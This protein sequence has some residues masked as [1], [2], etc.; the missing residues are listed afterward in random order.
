MR[1]I[2]LKSYLI[3]LIIIIASFC[4]LFTTL[5]VLYQSDKQTQQQ[6]NQALNSATKQ[7]HVQLIRVQTNFERPD[8]FPNLSLWQEAENYSGL[9]VRF[10]GLQDRVEQSIC[11]GGGVT[12]SW[13]DWFDGFYRW[14]FRPGKAVEQALSHAGKHYGS[15][16]VLPSVDIAL[17][18]AWQDVRKLMG[19]ATLTIVSLSILLYFAIGYALRPGRVIV[20]EL[21]KMKANEFSSR[22][23]DFFITEW[24][25]MGREMN[26]LAA[27]LQ[28]NLA[29]RK[30]L[31][32]KLV[33][34]Q[35][36]ERKFLARELHDEFGQ[37]LA[38][39]SAVASL[40]TQ[41]AEKD[42][43]P[44]A[45]Q[46]EKVSDITSYMMGL[47]RDMLIRLRPADFDELGLIDS[48]K[49]MI[50][51]WNSQSGG[52]TQYQLEV[53]GD[54]SD[55]N[56]T[57]PVSIFRMA[58]ECLTNIAK[59]SKASNALILLQRI[60][61]TAEPNVSEH[62]LLKIEDDGIASDLTFIRRSGIG[63][64]GLQERVDALGGTLQF[65][66]LT[67]SGLAIHI[68]IPLFNGREVG[69]E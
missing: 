67:P 66:T 12:R 32:L 4:L 18:N 30:A 54:F 55:L 6:T 37:S 19:L 42:Y 68:E 46:G 31:A 50:A 13:P 3:L 28:S 1:F 34:I 61:S 43:P 8:N 40:I 60:S 33:D 2:S 16:M 10:I 44:L 52:K 48:L 47:L 20:E 17:D 5:W 63:L 58:Q 29:E 57:L 62:I 26:Q 9:C 7:L 49:A 15:V 21:Q 35:E 38:G 56:D 45:K 41:L 23:P 53:I 59:H 51:G 39:L 64:L 69:D 24:Q 36:H 11:R 27:D 22:L 25:Y 65:K 14:V